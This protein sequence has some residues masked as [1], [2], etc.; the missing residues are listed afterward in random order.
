ME[1]NKTS[2]EQKYFELYGIEIQGIKIQ[3]SVYNVGINGAG[4]NSFQSKFDEKSIEI[5]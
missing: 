2:E 4:Y 5:Y 3:N 1:I